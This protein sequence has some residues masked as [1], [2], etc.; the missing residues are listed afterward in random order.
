[1]TVISVPQMLKAGKA[2]IKTSLKSKNNIKKSDFN[3]ILSDSSSEI[4]VKCTH[5]NWAF[6]KGDFAEWLRVSDCKLHRLML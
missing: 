3:L 5:Q 2:V 4:I 6:A 1:M